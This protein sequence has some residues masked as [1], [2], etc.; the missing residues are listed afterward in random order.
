VY[1][2]YAAENWHEGIV[3]LLLAGP[4]VQVDTKDNMGVR[5]CCMLL[6]MGMRVC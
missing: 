5:R 2:V 1:A 6:K 4:D 3:T